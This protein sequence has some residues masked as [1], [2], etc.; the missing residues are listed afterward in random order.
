M[1]RAKIAAKLQEAQRNA[2]AAANRAERESNIA[3]RRE[4]EERERAEAKAVTAGLN[5]AAA[6]HAEAA[7]ASVRRL[8][9]QYI[10]SSSRKE[11]KNPYGM[12]LEEFIPLEP[13]SEPPYK[14]PPKPR[15]SVGGVF[16]T[17]YPTPPPK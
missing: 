10:Q 6:A 8:R 14:Q 15:G 12:P 7:A 11:G 5:T 4:Q 9:E 17:Q 3:A 2:D 16:P 1:Q 13:K